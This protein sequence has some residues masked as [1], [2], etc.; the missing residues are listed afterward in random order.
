MLSLSALFFYQSFENL[1]VADMPFDLESFTISFEDKY[2]TIK[3]D[4]RNIQNLQ[5]VEVLRSEDGTNWMTIDQIPSPAKISSKYTYTDKTEF[6]PNT[7]NLYYQLK[8]ED[9][10]DNIEFS[11]VILIEPVIPHQASLINTASIF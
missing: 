11:E 9:K 3:W 4:I 7:E 8:F 10:Q 6:E 1:K 2:P 5:S